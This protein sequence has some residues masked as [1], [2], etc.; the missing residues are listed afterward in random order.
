MSTE[1]A[2]QQLRETA[3]EFSA[4]FVTDDYL[5]SLMPES[6]KEIKA[7]ELCSI[8]EILGHELACLR[9]FMDLAND[10]LCDMS[11]GNDLKIGIVNGCF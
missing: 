5:R 2:L 1:K 4:P 6:A 3:K 8:K 7:D 10:K 9:E 11:I